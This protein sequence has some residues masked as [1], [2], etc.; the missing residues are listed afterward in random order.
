MKWSFVVA[1]SAVVTMFPASGFA[2]PS[3]HAIAAE[4]LF[5]E[6]R[7]LLAE[8]KYKEACE[9]LAASEKL[10]PAVGTAYSLGECYEARGFT[11]SAWLTFHEAAG[12]AAQKGDPRRAAAEERAA[13]LETRLARLSIHAADSGAEL[14]VRIDGEIFSAEALTAP[15]PLNPGSHHVEASAPNRR[16]F[17]A[18]VTMRAEGGLS[19]LAIPALERVPEPP[20]RP[21]A[22]DNDR[23][24]TRTIGAIVAGAGA[25]TAGVGAILGLQAIVKGRTVNRACPNGAPCTDPD[26]VHSNDVAKTYADI[27]TVTLPIGAALL[28]VGGYLFFFASPS[29]SPARLEAS[30]SPTSSQLDVT[31]PW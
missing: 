20:P 1:A 26:V 14:T 13:N 17:S 25:L 23:G 8:H 16:P 7:E 22:R 29:K 11:A 30:L 10:D 5:R 6:G 12:Q 2:Q 27:S 21:I 18:D 4:Q 19:S 28:A 31:L 15:I 9:K 3:S 24:A